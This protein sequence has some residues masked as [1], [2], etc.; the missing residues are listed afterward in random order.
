VR[1]AIAV[2]IASLSLTASASAATGASVDAEGQEWA[3]VNVCGG[4]AMGVRAG[5]PGDA[6]DRPMA[7]R[8]SAQWLDGSGAWHAVPGSASPWLHAGPGRWLTSETGWTRAF[9]APVPGQ[10]FTLRGVVEMRWLSSSGGVA[11]AETLVTPQ[12]CTLR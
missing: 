9:S 12:G 7:T 6:L 4:S 2:I 10:T 5:Q 8:F 1:R 3:A 11:R